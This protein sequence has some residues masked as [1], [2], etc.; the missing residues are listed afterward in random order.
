M[1]TPVLCLLVL[2][3][4]GCDYIGSYVFP[5]AAPKSIWIDD[6]K[7]NSQ[8]F[9]A[10]RGDIHVIPGEA[11]YEIEFTDADGLSHTLYGIK[12]FSLTDVPREVK[13]SLPYPEPDLYNFNNTEDNLP[14]YSNGKSIHNGDVVVWAT[15]EQAKF[16]IDHDAKGNEKG[17][18]WARIW[19]RNK[20]CDPSSES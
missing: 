18:H 16:V 11:G 14:T 19:V 8:Y 5:P 4:S 2:L 17:R 12:R 20:V 13:S 15:G 3:V 1:R 6:G 10:C 9:V 7:D